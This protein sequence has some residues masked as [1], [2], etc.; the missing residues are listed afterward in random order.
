[1]KIISF[2]LNK[3]VKFSVLILIFQFNFINCRFE[4]NRNK[5]AKIESESVL[6]TDSIAKKM[7]IQKCMLC[8]ESIGKTQEE[9]LAPPFFEVKERYIKASIDK[10]DFITTMSFWIE[11]PS[12]DNSFMKEAIQDLG[13]MPKLNYS[14]DTISLIVNY[15]YTTNFKVPH[16]L[17]EHRKKHK[18]SIKHTH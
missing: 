14:N 8:H 16:W 2:F 11:N 18:N 10:N 1:M 15:I 3:T 13:I 17:E 4:K 7:F 5:N 9:M 6:I 12:V